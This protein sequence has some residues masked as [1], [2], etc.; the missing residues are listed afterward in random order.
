[1]LQNVPLSVSQT[2]IKYSRFYEDLEIYNYTTFKGHCRNAVSG[3][4]EHV[5]KMQYVELQ[6]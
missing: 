2:L 3:Y 1:M 6:G 4:I 5:T